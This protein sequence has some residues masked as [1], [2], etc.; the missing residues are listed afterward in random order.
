MKFKI[1]RTPHGSILVVTMCTAGI[2]MLGL[3]TYLWLVSNH[4]L[5]TMRSLAWNSALTVAEAGAE[6]ALTQVQYNDINHL[7]ANAWVNLNNGWYYKKRYVDSVNYYE[8]MVKQ[9]D[10]PVIISTATVPAPVSTDL[11]VTGMSCA[12]CARQRSKAAGAP[13]SP[14]FCARSSGQLCAAASAPR[15]SARPRRGS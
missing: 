5:S 9:V 11:A 15:T 3:A 12:N 14:T 7:S 2:I 4:N 6:E 1:N 13:R 8:V 10:P